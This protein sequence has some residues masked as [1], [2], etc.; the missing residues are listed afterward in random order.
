MKY[1]VAFPFRHHNEQ[2]CAEAKQKLVDAGFELVCNNTGRKLDREEQ[3]ALL[4]DA[5]AVIAGTEPYDKDMLDECENL[6][7]IIRFGVG[8]DNFDL[9]EMRKRG[10][11]V[12]VISNSSSVAEFAVTLILCMLKEIRLHDISVRGGGWTRYPTKELSKKTVGLIGFGRIGKRVAELLHG[13]DV[14]VLVYS[15]HMTAER[16]KAS[17]VVS[18]GLDEL[19]A[20]SDIVSLHLP[21]TEDSRHMVNADFIA[22]MKD[23]AYLINT[24]RGAIVDEQALYDALISGKLAGA[25]LDVY[26]TEPSKA[27][28]PLFTLDNVIVTPHTAALS[29]ETNYNGSLICAD[30][31]I[32]VANG[33]EPVIAVH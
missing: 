7:C 2:I 19:L 29:F 6:K 30:S 24:A 27:D 22:K 3:K 21:A 26:E 10:I 25:G 23:G 18:V 32:S 12:G 20:C 33:G 1:K 9:D 15:P 4:K 13:F 8:T 28:N 16:A 14:N 5:Y 31:I 11:K 17:G